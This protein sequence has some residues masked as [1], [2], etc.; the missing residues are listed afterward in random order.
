VPANAE[1][2]HGD[3]KEIA[4]D[5]TL[6]APPFPDPGDVLESAFGEMFD[7]LRDKEELKILDFGAAKL[8]NTVYL[9]KKGYQVQAVEFEKLLNEAG[10]AFEMREKAREYKDKFGEPVFP[11][12]FVNAKQRFDL[13]LLINVLSIMPVPAERL[14]VL[15][16]CR[17]K[18]KVGGHLFYYSMYGDKY[19]KAHCTDDVRIGDGYYMN[20][21]KHKSFYREF[22][23]YEVDFM[24]LSC[25]FELAHK[26]PI[27]NNHARLYRKQSSNLTEEM[28]PLSQI[29]KLTELGRSI[30]DPQTVPPKIVARQKD[31][32]PVIPNPEDLSLENLWLKKLKEIPH[33]KN[34]AADFHGLATLMLRRVFEPQLTNFKFKEREDQAGKRLVEIT[35]SNRDDRGFFKWLRDSTTIISSRRPFIFMEARNYEYVDNQEVSNFAKRL[36]E[37]DFE[38]GFLIYRGTNRSHLLKDCRSFAL[39]DKYVLPLVESDLVRLFKMFQANADQEILNFLDDRFQELILKRRRP[40]TKDKDQALASKPARPRKRQHVIFVS[41]SHKDEVQINRLLEHLGPLQSDK[42]EV[43][44][45]KKIGA[46]ASWLQEI[47][48]ALARAKV[49]VLLITINFLNS[50]FIKVKEVPDLLLRSKEAGLTVVPILAKHCAWQQVDWL[51]AMELRPKSTEPVWRSRGAHVDEELA[52]IANEVASYLGK[53]AGKAPRP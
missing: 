49:G 18:L 46:G 51:A 7:Y 12:A 1:E 27:K 5:V 6:S 10:Q 11:N 40:E 13:V 41:Y 38:F 44:S 8:R 20:K 23:D 22:E 14:M 28:I 9:L 26:I 25:G 50:K 48:Q 4:I 3:L 42:V 36:T 29:E 21:G 24:F 17:E 52:K 2:Q 34:G 16:Y 39:E 19:Y 32:Q 47:D 45:D 53:P 35:A 37:L 33:G 15:Q 30:E 31:I 43:W